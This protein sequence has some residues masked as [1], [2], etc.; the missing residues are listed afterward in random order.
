KHHA[1]VG[2]VMLVLPAVLRSAQRQTIR[3]RKGGTLLD[4]R[5]Y[6]WRRGFVRGRNRARGVAPALCALLAEGIIRSGLRL[7]TRALPALGEPGNYPRRGQ[8]ENVEI[9][10]EHRQ[11]RRRDRSARRGRVSL[12][13]NVYGTARANETLEHPRRRRRRAVSC[14]R[15][16]LAHDREPGRGMGA[17]QKNQSRR[18]HQLAAKVAACHDQKSDGGHRIVLF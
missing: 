9:A 18:C 6:P 11:P 10:R 8:P 2:R 12:L 13:R 17:I 16:A 14:A 7:E 1:A 5:E 15:L 3:W 4:G